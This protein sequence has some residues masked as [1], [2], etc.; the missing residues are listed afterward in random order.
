MLFN[1]RKELAIKLNLKRVI[2]GGRLYNYCEYADRISPDEYVDKVIKG[3]IQDPV[4]SFDLKNGFKC[5]KIIPE[6]IYD[7][8]SLNYATFIE[9]LNPKYHP[10]PIQ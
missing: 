9:W 3:K 4:L 2:A 1:A 5:V 6:Y 10:K 8:R 7:S